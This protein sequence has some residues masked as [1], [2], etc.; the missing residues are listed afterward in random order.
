MPRLLLATN[1]KGKA[2]EYRTLLRGIPYEMVTP[3]SQ[4]ITTE[5]DE[6]GGSFEENAR[7]K[8]TTLAR[9]SGLLALADDSG[10]EVDA[11]GGAPGALSH[12]FAGEGASDDDRIALLLAMLKNVPEKE[13][14]AQF[15]CVIAVATPE[16]KSELYTG[17]C[18]GVITNEPKGNNG[19]GYDPVFYLPE[20]GRTMAEL[21]LED[22]NKVSHRARAA[23][24]AREALER[25]IAQK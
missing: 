23:A 20:P 16:G 2:R 3:D 11:L 17:I 9:E 19:F 18:R 5:V 8:A 4:G 22:K 13:R 12:R 24:K 1:N 21:T 7:L 25:L 10:L 6:S 15:R 14:T